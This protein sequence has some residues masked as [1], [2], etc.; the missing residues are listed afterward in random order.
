LILPLGVID[1][2]AL[3]TTAAHSPFPKQFNGAV[4]AGAHV[5]VFFLL[6]RYYKQLKM[7][8]PRPVAKT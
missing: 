7:S 2:A 1:F 4:L 6:W 3:V 8:R 5:M